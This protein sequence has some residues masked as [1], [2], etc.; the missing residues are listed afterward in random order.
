MIRSQEPPWQEADDSPEEAPSEAPGGKFPARRKTVHFFW[1]HRH[2][3]RE[4]L[5]FVMV[6]FAGALGAIVHSLRSLVIYIGTRE[7][8]RH[9]VPFYVVRPILGAAIGTIF[10]VVLRAGLFSPSSGS[11]TESPY[12]FAA[13]GPL[14]G[15]FGD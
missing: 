4:S 2:T 7:L 15:R 13:V 8:R 10:Y 3:S 14:A 11:Q 9:W 1:L 6:A 5:F 12:G